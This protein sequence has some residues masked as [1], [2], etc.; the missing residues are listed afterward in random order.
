MS[1]VLRGLLEEQ[2]PVR[3]LRTILESFTAHAPQE[4]DTEQLIEKVRTGLRRQISERFSTTG[5][6]LMA[7]WSILSL[8]INSG[9]YFRIALPN[10]KRIYRSSLLTSSR[11]WQ[12]ICPT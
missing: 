5:S 9:R 12:P 8:S 4:K 11:I 1:E 2:I 6:E 10:S 7:F 3:D